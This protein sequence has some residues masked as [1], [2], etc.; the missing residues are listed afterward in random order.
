MAGCANSKGQ[1]CDPAVEVCQVD[2]EPPVFAD[3]PPDGQPL[4]GFGEVCTDRG[5]CASNLCILVGTSGECTMTCGTCPAG[6]GCLGVLG[7]DI[8]D[9][10]TFVCV[11][12]S[13]QLC[14][15]CTDDSE[16]TLIGMDKCVPYADGDFYCGQDCSTVSCP[17]GFDC[18]SVDIGG[19]DYEQCVAASGACDCTEANPGAMQPCNIT[20][21]WNVCVGSQTCG[22]AT[23]WGACEPPSMVDDPDSS[24]ADTNCDGIDGDMLRAIFVSPAGSNTGSCGLTYMTP[25]QTLPF[26]MFRATATGR[27]HVYAQTGTYGG[28]LTMTNG[29]SIFGGYNF[30]WARASYSMPGH[31]VTING[32]DVGVRFDAL[33]A[34]TWLDN[35]VVNSAAAG[36]GG[37]SIGIL[38]TSSSAAELRG[39]LV[40]PGPGGPGAAG[41]TGGNGA[42]GSAGGIGTPGCEESGGLCSGCAQPAP[43][44][45][46]GSSC[47]RQGGGGGVPGRS[48]GAG[49]AGAQGVG[50]TPGGAGGP[51]CG[52]GNGGVGGNGNNGGDGSPGGGGAALGAFSGFAYAPSN[53]TGGSDGAG[54]DGGGGGGGGGGGD[55]DCDSYGS[56]GG[57]GGGGGCGGGAGTGGTGGG[58]SFGVIALD[59]LLVISESIINGGAGGIGGAGGAGGSGGGGGG[60]GAGGPYGGGSEQDDGGMGGRGGNGGNGGA[61]GAGGGGGGGPSIGVVCLGS[62]SALAAAFA[63]TLA[64]GPAG[65]GGASSAPGATGTSAPTYNCPF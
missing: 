22:G 57:G 2:G 29:I 63:S 8:K 43:G 13:T 47:G 21:P 56:S 11:P 50:G 35:V 36:P 18:T 16:C 45:G 41:S 34:P 64:G 59:S 58:G 38:V 10:I 61:G 26:A 62:S 17:T 55:D 5:Q 65:A 9:Q 33:T 3:A 31:Q 44:P 52:G 32:G 51:G 19:T 20:T 42:P 37:S 24:Y 49:A 30:N 53:G 7:I 40:N 28:T 25:C 54:G 27:P 15:P 23:G 48:C 12:E 60:F 46:G 6:Y 4:R 39:V 14:S 1:E